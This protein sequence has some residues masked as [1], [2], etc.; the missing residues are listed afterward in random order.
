MCVRTSKA[1]GASLVVSSCSIYNS[2][3]RERPDLIPLLYEPLWFDHCVLAHSKYL[4]IGP[5]A[6]SVLVDIADGHCRPECE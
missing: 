6:A 2:I 3:L 1:G 4:R 5:T